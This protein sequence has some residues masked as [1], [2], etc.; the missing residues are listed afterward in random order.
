MLHTIEHSQTAFI[1]YFLCL[2]Q[3]V[4]LIRLQFASRSLGIG[5][6]SGQ[7]RGSVSIGA[8]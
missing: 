5:R 1:A 2:V 8:S 7:I 6:D 3:D 4:I